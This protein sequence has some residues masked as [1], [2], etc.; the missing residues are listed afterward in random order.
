M[1]DCLFNSEYKTMETQN[2][3]ILLAQWM[4]ESHLIN[5]PPN[6]MRLALSEVKIVPVTSKRFVNLE[7]IEL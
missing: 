3:K 1:C 7:I 6:R 4:A 2:I 5:I